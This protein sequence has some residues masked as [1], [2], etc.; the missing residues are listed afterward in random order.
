MAD[1]A[2]SKPSA[3]EKVKELSADI[4]KAQDPE[5]ATMRGWL[6]SWEPR[7]PCPRAWITAAA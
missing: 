7:P 2:L 5:I 1:V 4:K 3:S 6:S